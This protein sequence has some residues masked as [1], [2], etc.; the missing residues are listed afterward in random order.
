MSVSDKTS[1]LIESKQS[2]LDRFEAYSNPTDT[3]YSQDNLTRESFTDTGDGYIENNNNKIWNISED[4][5]PAEMSYLRDLVNTEYALPDASRQDRRSYEYGVKDEGKLADSSQP[6]QPENYDPTKIGLASGKFTSS[7]YRYQPGRAEAEGLMKDGYG[8]DSGSR[9]VDINAKR[10]DANLAYDAATAYEALVHS[11]RN[12]LQNR[13]VRKREDGFYDYNS[14]EGLR[15]INEEEKNALF[16]SGSS[17][18]YTNRDAIFA[19]SYDPQ[20][21]DKEKIIKGLQQAMEIANKGKFPTSKSAGDIQQIV[22]NYTTPLQRAANTVS[23]FGA[24]LL[25]EAIVNPIDALGEATGLFDLGSEEEKS[26]A[27]NRLTGYDPS[28]S[29]AAMEEVGRQWDIVTNSEASI[30]ERATAAAKGIFEAFTTPEMAGT[31]LGA[32]LAWAGPGKFLKAFGVG[33]KF[34]KANKAL[35]AEIAA[36]KLTAAEARAK[37]ADLFMSVDNAKSALTAQAGFITAAAGNVNDQYDEFVKNNN[38]VELEGADKAEWFA[39]RFSIQ[40]VN[41]NLDKLVD[42]KVLQAPGVFKSLVP[43]V[44]GMTNK[45]FAGVAKTLVKGLIVTG[46]SMGAEAAQEYAQTS[47]ELFNARYGSEQF[48][49]DSIVDFLS[50]ERNTREA[51]IA[52]LAGA[53]GAPQFELMGVPAQALGLVGG[54]VGEQILKA[55]PE[56]KAPTAPITPQEAVDTELSTEEVEKATV[57][58]RAKA[59]ET[60][61]KFV[62]MLNDGE[63][64]LA[65]AADFTEQDLVTTPDFKEK[66]KAEK[67]NY[68]TLLKDI[69]EAT[70]VFNSSVQDPNNLTLEQ[71]V[72]LKVLRQARRQI[73]ENTM[74]DGGPPTLG[75]GYNAADVVEE[76]LDTFDPNGEVTISDEQKA[77]ALKYLQDNEV[78]AFRFKNLQSKMEGKDA[79]VVY[80]ESV[81]DG[82]NSASSYRSRIRQLVNTPGVSKKLVKDEVGK[83]DRFLSSQLDRKAQFDAVLKEVQADVASYNKALQSGKKLVKPSNRDFKIN[84]NNVF[85]NIET[86][87]D[88][89]LRVQQQAL[90]ISD[91]IQDTIEHL[92]TTKAR[93]SSD[94]SKVLGTKVTSADTL[95]VPVS[96]QVKQ[97]VQKSRKQNDQFFKKQKFTK[98]IVDEKT[99][100]DW[101]KKGGDY[102]TINE[103]KIATKGNKLK[104]TADDTVLLT[105][106]DVKQGSTSS[107][108]LAEAKR[109]GAKVIVEPSLA[110]GNESKVTNLAKKYGFNARKLDTSSTYTWLSD[111]QAAEFDEKKAKKAEAEKTE[112]KA[113]SNLTKAYDL[114]YA[115]KVKSVKD[116]S[117]EDQTV[118]KDAVT[119]AR[120]YFPD[121][122]TKSSDKKMVEYVE[123]ITREEAE[124]L[125][126]TLNKIV[127]TQGKSSEAYSLAT[128]KARP[129]V[130]ELAEKQ[131]NARIERLSKGSEMLA[132]WRKAA[133]EDKAGGKPFDE[134]VKETLSSDEKIIV[135]DMLKNSLG[136]DLKG[137]FNLTTVYAYIDKNEP[138]EGY[139]VTAYEKDAINFSESTYH[140][141]ELNP[142]EYVTVNQTTPLN[143]INVNNLKAEGEL[144]IGFNSFVE[145]AINKLKEAVKF[146]TKESTATAIKIPFDLTNSPASSFVVD[147]E[148]NVNPN[149]AVAIRIG[150]YNFLR[151]DGFLLGKQRKTK[152]DVARILG[153]HVSQVS[154]QAVQVM[155]DNGM[156]Y[157]TVINSVGKDIAGM[158]GIARKDNPTVDVRAYDALVAEL[159]NMAMLMGE[160][161]GLLEYS[162]DYSSADYAIKVLGKNKN[163]VEDNGSK[164]QFIKLKEGKTL[165]Q[166][167]ELEVRLLEVSTLANEINEFIPGTNTTRKEPS[168]KRLSKDVKDK[169]KDKIRKEKLGLNIA[170]KSQ[171]AMDALMNTE[172]EADLDLAREALEPETMALLKARLGYIDLESEQFTK[173][174]YKEQEVQ[175]SINRDIDKSFEHLDWLVKSSGD[176]ATKSMWFNYFFSKNGRFFVDSNTINPQT[177]KHLHRFFVQPKSHKNT[178]T[179]SRGIF[180][181]GDEVVTDKVHYAL[182]QAF[183][184]ATDKKAS[185]EI[186]AFA[187]LAISKVTKDGI[188]KVKKEFL[189]TGKYVLSTKIVDGKEVTDK[190]LE[191]EHIG[192]ALQ[193]FK[194]LES[195]VTAKGKPFTSS[196]TAEFDAV[197]SGFGLKLMQMPIIGDLYNWLSKVGIVTD[198]QQIEA[199]KDDV[200]MNNLLALDSFDDSYVTLAKKVKNLTFDEMQNNSDEPFI[201]QG[202]EDGFI[203]SMWNA[204]SEVLPKANLDGTVDKALRD[205]FKYPF[206][207]FNYASSIKSIRNNL[208][209]EELSN[210]IAKQIAKTDLSDA[211]NPVTKLMQAYL[212]PKASLKELKALQDKVRSEPF[213]FIKKEDGRPLKQYLAAMIDASYGQQVEDALNDSFKE[214]VDAQEVINESF[215]AMFEVFNISFMNKVEEVRKANKGV[216]SAEQEKEIYNSLKNQWPAIKG[217]L[218]SMEEDMAD[219]IGIYDTDTASPYGPLTGRKSARTALGPGVKRKEEGVR[220]TQMVKQ[221]ASAISAGSVVPIHYIDGAVMANTILDMKGQVTSIHDAIM[222]NLKDFGKAQLSY[223]KAMVDVSSQYSFINEILASLDKMI[224]AAPLTQPM[225]RNKEVKLRNG[226]KEGASL[227]ILNTR[228]KMANLVNDVNRNREELF[229]KLNGQVAYGMHMAGTNDGVYNITGNVNYTPIEEIPQKVYNVTLYKKK[230]S[231]SDL[232]K[233]A[234]KLACNG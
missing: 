65:V 106:L 170:E 181:I 210:N 7:D 114:L 204:L 212:G 177:D 194:F 143:S 192:H 34:D 68:K 139:K 70:D 75:S 77:L 158:L 205:L 199:I 137:K 188:A 225:Y 174:S 144:S 80:D 9:G 128:E 73:F 154:E 172:W 66:V 121:S 162:N 135:K 167:D 115:S 101:W 12:N 94:I 160:V 4:W 74:E 8:W 23:G 198:P 6:Y 183:G 151:N 15:A 58:S 179:H 229:T 141:L 57:A 99:S 206:M 54:K 134:W 153:M 185:K 218:S 200:S 61:D 140:Q 122:K 130:L 223:N 52:A 69:D 24:T 95:V 125:E 131:V 19:D 184:F 28:L 20:T 207:T 30:G 136:K 50:D 39:T 197:T 37:K 21:I 67:A 165:K 227:F 180:K 98:A 111:E 234:S 215:Q 118:F 29:Q 5:S 148:F 211:D 203:G 193:G 32:I 156:L 226:E 91:S 213:A 166:Q 47:A 17:E 48:D 40:L 147:K 178:Y 152:D 31:S 176:A 228:N 123:R 201:R 126:A 133:E 232:N 163:L 84:D 161:E 221:L 202:Q 187:E 11:N 155:N 164:V 60:V 83:I 124:A 72:S 216:I 120:K 89:S 173:L 224:D 138:R 113:K 2:K 159:G 186:K 145:Q 71:E 51:G 222:P 217:P 35:N 49:A 117:I 46:A 208:L 219:M 169:A 90:D 231:V 64:N 127:D 103:S 22:Q 209:I 25:G 43:A 109:A 230:M 79:Q 214:F 191:I 182:A 55:R 112:T 220:A 92:Q 100:L 119:A 62:Q 1:Y 196:I 26:A 38:G 3:N 41:Q 132:D 168:F 97:S 82:T 142:A 233:E 110:K 189:E 76:Y 190:A 42:L 107:R 10:Q 108:L 86:N 175:A 45:E 102:Y 78:P 116:L 63:F 56:Q 85:I 93:Y 59:S 146:P 104:F 88:G 81:G 96:T 157:K 18:Y 53:G 33:S 195:M 14:P 44:K 171:E 149:V 87:R 129:R 27:I 16:G 105:T 36:G 13:L 150:L